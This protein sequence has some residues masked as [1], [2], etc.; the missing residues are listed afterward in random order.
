MSISWHCCMSTNSPKCRRKSPPRMGCCTSA[1]MKIHGNDRR[2]L[3][4]RVSE[5][6][7]YV[8]MGVSFTTM[9]VSLSGMRRRSASEEGMV[10][11]SEAVSTRKRV[12]VVLS[13]TRNRQLGG[14][15][16]RTPV[17]ASVRPG[18]FPNCTGPCTS[19]LLHRT[20]RDTSLIR[21]FRT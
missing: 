5:R 9:R 4:L 12:C 8:L 18:S 15:G 10:P 1:M 6:F 14:G 19:G 21:N 13:L 20:W 16:P 7:L 3:R 2:S 11:T 17:A